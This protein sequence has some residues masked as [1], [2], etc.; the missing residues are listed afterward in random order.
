VAVLDPDHGHAALCRALSRSA[1]KTQ[2]HSQP[3]VPRGRACVCASLASL[4]GT[5]VCVADR[6]RPAQEDCA[7]R[8]ERAQGCICRRSRRPESKWALNARWWVGVFMA[9]RVSAQ[10]DIGRHAPTHLTPTTHPHTPAFRRC[11]SSWVTFAMR[12]RSRS[13][14][15]RMV[16]LTSRRSTSRPCCRDMLRITLTSA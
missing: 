11:R 14:W 8:H 2:T 7:V 6:V 13:W 9:M 1:K 5:D 3:F 12:P 15:T 16:A 4:A 10:L